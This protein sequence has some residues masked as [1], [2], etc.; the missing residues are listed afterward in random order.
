MPPTTASSSN[1]QA[2]RY[3]DLLFLAGQNAGDTQNATLADDTIE[4]QT[5]AVMEKIRAILE[6]HKLTMANIVQV[7]VYLSNVN[8]LDAMDAAYSKHF[9]GALPAR[10]IVEVSRL[11]R[12]ALVE[13]AVIAG[14]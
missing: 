13:I 3:G 12:G 10:T 14:R 6:S 5:H 1:V 8:D 7:T 2:T 9:R 4:Q 11:R